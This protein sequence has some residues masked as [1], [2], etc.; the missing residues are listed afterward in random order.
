M[1]NKIFLFTAIPIL[2]IILVFGYLNI[3][4]ASSLAPN[5]DS[6]SECK[7]IEY[8]GEDRIDL[9][10]ISSYED[11]KHYSDYLFTVE[12]YKTYR[13]YFNVQFLDEQVECER[14]K[15][16]ALLCYTDQILDLAKK[17]EHDYLI[18]LKEDEKQIR[19]SA[20]GKVVSINKVHEDSVLI[21]ELGHAIANFAEEYGGAKI[22]P[23]SKNC[24]S[25]CNKFEGEVDSCV[26]ECSTS[27]HY[28]SIPTGVMRSLI[29]DNYGIYDIAL[30]TE[31]LEKNK[32]KTSSIT[33]NQ[34]FEG[35]LCAKKAQEIKIFQSENGFDIKTDNALE[36]IC[37]PDKGLSGALC[38]GNICNI[39]V[40]F[41]DAQEHTD[42]TLNGETYLH[43]EIPLSLYVEKNNENPIVEI[44]FDNQLIGTINTAEA[45]VTACKV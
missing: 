25:Q 4:Q 24:Q 3:Q 7:S 8:N 17:C 12:P 19:S 41:T 2:G 32:P 22:P 33:G 29:T 18:V 16:I 23:G 6:V 37:I 26:Q 11:A 35:G 5:I 14:Y 1:E 28:R 34:V 13:D 42:E 10:F 39:N 40:L 31:L 9:L 30:L 45:G 44:T 36:E 21:H 15:D 43:P 38:I 27:T 20:Y